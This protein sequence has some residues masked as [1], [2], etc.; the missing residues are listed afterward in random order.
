MLWTIKKIMKTY[1][2]LPESAHRTRWPNFYVPKLQVWCSLGAQRRVC[3]L[4]GP[5]GYLRQI[6]RNQG[7]IILQHERVHYT[8]TKVFSC[9]YPVFSSNLIRFSGP[10]EDWE[11][12]GGKS[13]SRKM[14]AGESSRVRVDQKHW[15][16]IMLVLYAL[17]F[18][19]FFRMPVGYSSRMLYRGKKFNFPFML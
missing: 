11:E 17:F 19:S 14:H 1:F 16:K 7:F 3:V 2:P 6:S 18:F 4:I 9:F 12:I 5:N 15:E 10:P 8:L 13:Y